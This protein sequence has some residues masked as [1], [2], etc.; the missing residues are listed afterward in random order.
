MTD[1]RKTTLKITITTDAVYAPA[2][3]WDWES[4]LDLQPEDELSVEV[5]P[6]SDTDVT[7]PQA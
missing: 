4:L 1:R 2:D 6:D 7:T 3:R 5:F